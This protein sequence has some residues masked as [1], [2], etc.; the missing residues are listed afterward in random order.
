MALF[1]NKKK[2]KSKE[3][4]EKEASDYR[5][6]KMAS[7]E[8]D[9]R[10]EKGQLKLRIII[11]LMGKPKDL[12]EK[13]FDLLLKKLRDDE[14]HHV[15]K[16]DRADFKQHGKLWTTFAE[17]ELWVKN[18]SA[19]TALLFDY[20]PSSVEVLEPQNFILRSQD[21]TDYLNDMQARLHQADMTVKNLRAEVQVLKKQAAGMLNNLVVLSL[22]EG[23]KTLEEVCEDIGTSPEDLE[24]YMKKF[25]E[26]GKIKMDGKKY[27]LVRKK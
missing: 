23:P 16:E 19:L 27:D 26:F 22:R 10:L 1:R 24:P 15:I 18:F 5:K 12:M 25:V 11:E 2:E 14:N 7:M 6:K 8:D 13:T 17:V 21:F 3:D 4:K 9:E 20:L